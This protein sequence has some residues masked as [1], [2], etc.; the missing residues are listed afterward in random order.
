M[1][2]LFA[3][4]QQLNSRDTTSN[5]ALCL[6]AT[7]KGVLPKA[8]SLVGAKPPLVV[9]YICMLGGELSSCTCLHSSWHDNK[10]LLTKSQ[11]PVVLQASSMTTSHNG[12]LEQ[13]NARWKAVIPLCLS[14]SAAGQLNVPMMLTDASARENM[15]GCACCK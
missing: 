12:S 8:R 15:P 1:Y 7:A 11:P 3:S 4:G 9:L 10:F 2:A 13:G 5:G 14:F 6:H